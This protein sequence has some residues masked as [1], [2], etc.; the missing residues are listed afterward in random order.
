[1]APP[2]LQ[3]MATRSCIRHLPSLVDVGSTPYT[4]L[5]PILKKIQ[6][7]SHLHTLEQASPHIADANAEL[8]RA[9]IARDIPGWEDKIIEPK[10]PRSWWKVYRKLIR[11]EQL[12]KEEQEKEL[13]A[14]MSGLSRDR[15]AN[16]AM[17]VSKVIPQQGASKS[18]QAFVDGQPNPHMGGG[19]RTT[20]ALQNAKRGK[21]VVAAIRRQSALAARAK[22]I[23]RRDEGLPN[24]IGKNQIQAAPEWMVRDQRKPAVLVARSQAPLASR[25]APTV[26][27]PKKAVPTVADRAL[28]EAIRNDNTAREAR[29]RAL[30]QPNMKVQEANPLPAPAPARRVASQAVSPPRTATPVFRQ[31]ADKPRPATSA[32]LPRKASPVAA[33]PV[34]RKRPAAAVFMPAKKRKV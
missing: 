24:Y 26:F 20:P 32:E 11:E 18:R 31:A 19:A 23:G 27:A 30:T 33:E 2:S 7:P 16:K 21:D 22:G 1:M 28:S 8:W 9:F 10:N 17:F 12:A 6:N 13:E 15:Q 4:L 5:R 34:L 14:A 25:N 3:A 29:L